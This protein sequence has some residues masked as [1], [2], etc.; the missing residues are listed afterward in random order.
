M[1]IHERI[2]ERIRVTANER[3]DCGVFEDIY[4]GTWLDDVAR[5][6]LEGDF[7]DILGVT[8]P[9]IEDVKR[10]AVRVFGPNATVEGPSVPGDFAF[11]NHK[12]LSENDDAWPDVAARSVAAIYAALR[13]IQDY[14]AKP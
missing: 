6:F 4:A 1:S 8:E 10:E 3:K 13:T 5:A 14:E 11:A 9:T 12:Y 7:D 2:A